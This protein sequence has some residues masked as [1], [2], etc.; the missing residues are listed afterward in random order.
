MM[1]SEIQ[2]QD[3]LLRLTRVLDAPRSL[4]FGW[5]TTAE[6]LQQWFGAPGMTKCEIEM[7]FRVGGSFKQKMQIAGV[8]EFSSNAVYEEIVVPEKI[9]YRANFGTTSTLVTVE[10][11][12]LGKQTRL[13]LTHEGT[14]DESFIKKVSQ[15][16]TSALDR[17][18]E[19]VSGETVR[20]P[21]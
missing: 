2:V 6:K 5:W 12:D 3:N 13:V 7:D 10:F 11:F 4:V 15:G 14:I 18:D 19:L 9:V 8:G 21:I 16:T 1:K 20:N 17:L